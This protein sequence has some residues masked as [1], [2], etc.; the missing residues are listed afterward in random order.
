MKHKVRLRL[1]NTNQ[2]YT[3]KVVD[4]N[5]FKTF[6]GIPFSLLELALVNE[7]GDIKTALENSVNLAQHAEQ[8]G[9]HRVWLAEHHNTPGVASSAASVLLS[10]IAAKP[11]RGRVGAAG[12]I[13]A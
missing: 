12:V 5:M 9:Y 11:K 3:F 8:W 2:K 7:N 10:Y 6:Q 4:R 13:Q 1:F